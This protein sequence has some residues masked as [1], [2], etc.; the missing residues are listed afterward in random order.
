MTPRFYKQEKGLLLAPQ[1]ILKWHIS[2]TLDN[3]LEGFKL[4]YKERGGGRLD[5]T[6]PAVHICRMSKRWKET[7]AVLWRFEG[8]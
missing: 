2:W 8:S 1:G 4:F 3:V 5:L 6:L 7:L